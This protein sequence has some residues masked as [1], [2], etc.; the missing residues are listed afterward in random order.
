MRASEVISR[1]RREGFNERQG[2]GSHIVFSKE[3]RTVIVSNHRGD[4]P[5]GT[6][7]QICK[8]AGWEYPPQR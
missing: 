8:R 3:S 6:L 2:H 5:K 7:R 1:L 4:V